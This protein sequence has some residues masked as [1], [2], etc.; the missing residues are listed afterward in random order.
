MSPS[1]A[2]LKD[3]PPPPPT[4]S[5][6]VSTSCLSA[7]THRKSGP[8]THT[9]FLLRSPPPSCQEGC[10]QEGC[11]QEGCAQ[12]GCAQESEEGSQEG[13]A[14]EEVNAQ[15][16]PLLPPPTA[17]SLDSRRV[18][19]CRSS[20]FNQRPSRGN[21]RCTHI[22][23]GETIHHHPLNDSILKR[24][25]E[26]PASASASSKQPSS[27]DHHNIEKTR[28]RRHRLRALRWT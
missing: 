16:A 3:R 17:S 4:S 14:Q 5:G 27:A 21:R 25:L 8:P 12:E 7:V 22:S 9:L 20:L 10:A 18:H 11:A 28:R 24:C 6:L 2:R 19:D 26:H 1:R 15:P 23:P 13:C